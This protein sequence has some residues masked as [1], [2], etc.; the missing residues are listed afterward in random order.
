LAGSRL[1]FKQTDE[2]VY[3]CFAAPTRSR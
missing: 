2:S 1:F 3:G